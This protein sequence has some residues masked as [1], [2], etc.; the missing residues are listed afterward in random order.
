MNTK[1]KI[2]PPAL[3]HDAMMLREFGRKVSA[4]G[5]VERRVVANLF[6]H[7]AQHGWQ[8][9]H[10]NDG[11]D[12]TPVADAKAAM[13]LMFNLDE[14]FVRIERPRLDDESI[15]GWLR[16]VNGNGIDILSDYSVNLK[17]SLKDFNPEDYE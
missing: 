14:S 13:E 7:L 16:F 9:V 3:D 12:C 5:K 10:V 17:S 1:I 15:S 6:A 11:S 8:L 2:D 4:T